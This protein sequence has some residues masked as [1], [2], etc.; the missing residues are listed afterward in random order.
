MSQVTYQAGAYM[1]LGFYS[2]KQVEEFCSLLDGMLAHVYP[3]A[4]NKFA[5]T[6]LYTWVERGTAGV[7]CVAQEHNTTCLARPLDLETR[8]LTMRQPHHY[9]YFM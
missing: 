8:A 7:K 6:H 4:L 5:S 1:Y 9:M 2:M 3:P